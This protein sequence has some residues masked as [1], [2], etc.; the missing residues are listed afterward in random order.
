MS[1]SAALQTLKSKHSLKYVTSELS[2]PYSQF[3]CPAEG[4]R[5]HFV[6]V[7][8]CELKINTS[9]IIILCVEAFINNLS[10]CV[11]GKTNVQGDLAVNKY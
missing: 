1:R 6:Q 10:F 3:I 8:L 9:Y 2:V 5:F 4:E 11:T 7:H